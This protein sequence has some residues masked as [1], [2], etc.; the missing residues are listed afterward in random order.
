M[1]DRALVVFKDPTQ[2]DKDDRYS[3]VTYLHWG[4]DKV[5]ELL[6]KTKEIMEGRGLDIN[7]TP[8]RF[9]GVCHILM[10]GNLSLGTWNLPEGLP[11]GLKRRR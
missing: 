4:G 11:A 1:G 2:V 7:Y 8:A 3:P 9:I 5:P 6:K 10:E